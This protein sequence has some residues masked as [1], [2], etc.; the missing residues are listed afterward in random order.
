MN[1]SGL[2]AS[3]RDVFY[4]AA[5]RWQEVVIGDLPT[6]VYNGRVVDDLLIDVSVRNIDGPGGTLGGAS[7]DRFRTR[8]LLPYHG[9][10]Q[11]DTADL[12][13]MEANGTLRDVIVHEIGHV[14]GI[15]ILWQALGLL[16]GANT[17]NPQFTGPQATAEYN[18]LHSGNATSVP[19]A[20]T[21]GSGTRDSHWRESVF[22]SEL[23][24]G[25]VGPGSS[26]PLSR[27]TIASLAD[28]GYVVDLGAADAY[29]LA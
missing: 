17:S 4:E 7:A 23:M 13:R 2:T 6:A 14:L 21:G 29:Y 1:F 24:T 18:A 8:T 11:F 5:A 22:A 28:M 10:I 12:S 16:S 15:G 27:L 3:Q 19:V 26:L 20:N 25:Y 9:T